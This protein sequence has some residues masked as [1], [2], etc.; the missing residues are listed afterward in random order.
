MEMMIARNSCY[1]ASVVQC[2]YRDDALSGQSTATDTGLSL[3]YAQCPSCQSIWIDGF[4][5]NYLKS[6]LFTSSSTEGRPPPDATPFCPECG[7]ALVPATEE[8]IPRSVTAYRCPQ[9]HGYL[10]P[11][12]ELAKFKEAQ[13]VK[14]AYHRLWNIPLPDMKSVLLGSL[15]LVMAIGLGIT[16]LEIQKSRDIRSSAARV[17]TSQTA[18]A[19]AQTRSVVFSAITGFQT[20]VVLHI[21]SLSGFAQPM[22]TKDQTIHTLTVRDIPSGSY[23]YYFTV[24]HGGD[25]VR[26]ETYVFTME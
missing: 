26:S 22:E 11:R 6:D 25:F 19:S 14:L 20:S 23:E 8:S 21:D 15:G 16:V 13:E 12:N 3:H 9:G 5:A 7:Q 1:N 2:P 17:I 18:T 24:Q 4:D 10:F